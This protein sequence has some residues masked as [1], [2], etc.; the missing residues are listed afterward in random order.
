MRVM[1]KLDLWMLIAALMLS[2]LLVPNKAAYVDDDTYNDEGEE[3]EEFAE[4]ESPCRA[5]TTLS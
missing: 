1:M 3:D 5:P 2:L 4:V